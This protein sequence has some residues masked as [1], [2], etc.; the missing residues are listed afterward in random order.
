MQK[1]RTFLTRFRIPDFVIGSPC[2]GQCPRRARENGSPWKQD[3]HP[4]Q[5]SRGGPH[6][7]SRSYNSIWMQQTRLKARAF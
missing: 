4:T 6:C 7:G 1:A 3:T 5:H 2:N